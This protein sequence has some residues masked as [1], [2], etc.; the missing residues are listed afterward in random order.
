VPAFVAGRRHGRG[1]WSLPRVRLLPRV[2]VGGV[3]L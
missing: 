2:A 1:S 3:G